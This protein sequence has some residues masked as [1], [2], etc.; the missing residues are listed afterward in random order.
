MSRRWIREVALTVSGKGGSATFDAL[1]IDFDVTATIGSKQNTGSISVWNLSP[2]RRAQ[3][4]EE[5]DEATLEA[6]YR[7]GSKGLVFKGAIR[8]VTHGLEGADVRSTLDLGDGDAA[9]NKTGVSRTF[10]A[11]TKPR[12]MVE[13]I[14][15][16]MKG[17]EIGD[18]VGLDDMPAAARP[19]SVYGWA[20]RELDTLGRE[21]GFYW[22]IQNGQFQAVKNDRHMGRPVVISSETGMIGTPEVTD[23]GVT[24]TTLLDT[25]IRPGRLIDVRSQFLDEN[26]GRDKRASDKGGGLF[27]V[28]QVQ[29]TGSNR[30]HDFYA[31]V[32]GARAQGDKVQK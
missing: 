12:E 8:D 32:Q 19:V 16:R 6:G 11:G 27:R 10:P 5:F 9:I 31:V 29:F 26:S 13:Y 3:L 2:A 17:V 4:G 24:V 20:A 23:K 14:A 1:K 25:E 7:D 21:H 30:G 28:S 18:L 15:G 22:S